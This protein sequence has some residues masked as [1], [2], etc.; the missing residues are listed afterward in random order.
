MMVTHIRGVAIPPPSKCVPKIADFITNGKR[1]AATAK[2]QA[3]R[4]ATKRKFSLEWRYLSANDTKSL[5]SLFDSDKSFF[6]SV[7]YIDVIKGSTSG[8]F[9]AE[10][11]D[12]ETYP[13]LN[14]D[15]SIKGY[16]DI[17]VTLN[18]Q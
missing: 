10:D 5:V 1:T 13:V 2:L 11:R 8:T 17:K 4:I 3:N 15:G 9:C 14:K 6:F 18:E 7:D 16:M 12:F